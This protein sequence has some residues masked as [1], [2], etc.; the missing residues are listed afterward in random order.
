MVQERRDIMVSS[1]SLQ[2]MQEMKEQV[3]QKELSLTYREISKDDF[4]QVV[5]EAS[6]DQWV[7]VHLFKEG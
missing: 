6:L 4:V 1:L 3:K 5:T 7:V 2:R